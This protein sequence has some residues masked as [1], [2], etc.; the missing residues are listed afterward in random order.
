MDDE[1]NDFRR[2][3]RSRFTRMHGASVDDLLLCGRSSEDFDRR[4][5]AEVDGAWVVCVRGG[6]PTLVHRGRGVLTDVWLAPSGEA[7]AAG[8]LDGE[9]GLFAFDAA[10]APSACPRKVIDGS[11]F[12]VWGLHD[13]LVFA[14]GGVRGDAQ[15]WVRRGGAW[16]L[17]PWSRTVSHVHGVRDDVVFATGSG[18][19]AWWDGAAW[20]AMECPTDVTLRPVYAVSEDEAYAVSHDGVLLEGSVYGWAQRARVPETVMTPN[21][22]ARR[23]G[24]VVVAVGNDGLLRLE[25]AELSLL[26]KNIRAIQTL[27]AGDELLTLNPNSAQSWAAPEKYPSVLLSNVEPLVGR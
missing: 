2:K 17:T 26:D 5:D 16:E 11:V 12:G 18:S 4:A 6:A 8:V 10:S 20:N 23:R 9:E 25:G 15:C 3:A 21:G 27:S 24:E 7:F 1:T 19:V 13:G 22:V 14:W